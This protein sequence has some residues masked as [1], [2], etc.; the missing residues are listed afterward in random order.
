MSDTTDAPARA[1]GGRGR[2]Y[3]ELA[4]ERRAAILE[5]F[6]VLNRTRFPDTMG[7]R[8]AEVRHGYA[9]LE[10]ENREALSNLHGVMGV[11]PS[12]L[13]WYGARFGVERR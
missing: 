8:V 11:A 6:Q 9:R 5:H 12:L 7:F 3:P 13:D 4:A 2:A 1:S 10:V